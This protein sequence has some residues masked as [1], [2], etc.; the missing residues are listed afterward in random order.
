MILESKLNK[1]EKE[2]G[3]VLRREKKLIGNIRRMEDN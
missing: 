3:E 1:L 2:F